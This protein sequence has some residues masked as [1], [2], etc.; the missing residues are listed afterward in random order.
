MREE[1]TRGGWRKRELLPCGLT[2]QMPMIARGRVGQSQEPDTQCRPSLYV[3]ETQLL[4][5]SLLSPRMYT[6]K[7]LGSKVKPT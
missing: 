4:E 7:K 3:A 6:N 2:L 5:P 1:G